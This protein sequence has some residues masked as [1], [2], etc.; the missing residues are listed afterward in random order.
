[1]ETIKL[2][3][4]LIGL[5]GL[6]TYHGWLDTSYILNDQCINDDFK[7]GYIDFNSD[8]YYYY[9]DNSQ[10]M[11]DLCKE[12]NG[13]THLLID[14]YNECGITIDQVDCLDYDSPR[15]YNFRSDHFHLDYKIDNWDTFKYES[16]NL[17]MENSDDFE[18]FLKSNYSSY[19]GFISFGA[20]NFKDW[21]K[22]FEQKCEI[23]IGAVFSF[24]HNELN[25]SEYLYQNILE[26][27]EMYYS[28][29]VDYK[30]LE[31]LKND[32]KL[33]LFVSGA[34]TGID[35]EMEARALCEGLNLEFKTYYNKPVHE[36]NQLTQDKYEIE[37]DF[38]EAIQKAY[39]EIDSQTLKLF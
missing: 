9:F 22:R 38:S 11:E 7:E 10:Y 31:D 28:E 33:G 8:Y 14:Q 21:F 4:N 37:F 15:G 32:I 16:I 34:Y 36:V 25:N 19:D 6:T 30:P 12:L 3:T 29:Y 26:G 17:V 39:N 23:A 35:K 5:N 1:M 18:Y 27:I 24:I 2:S 13:L 20:N